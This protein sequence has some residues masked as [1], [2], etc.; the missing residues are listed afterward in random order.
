MGRERNR[1]MAR[2]FREYFERHFWITTSGNFSTP[3][4]LCSVMELGADRIMFAVDYPM[5]PN[6]P[7]AAWV[8][9]IPLC[10]ENLAKIMHGNAQRL[11]K[12]PHEH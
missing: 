4:L 8:P 2:T 7:A 3:A 9:T 5:V 11:L 1:R 10:R 12:L 6:E